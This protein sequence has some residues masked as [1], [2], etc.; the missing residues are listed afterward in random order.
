[1]MLSLMHGGGKKIYV[2]ELD[3]ALIFP[4]GSANPFMS[5]TGQWQYIIRMSI[6]HIN[7]YEFSENQLPTLGKC[8]DTLQPSTCAIRST[9]NNVH[10]CT[11]KHVSKP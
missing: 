1:M 9:N 5:H 10:S 7:K 2:T 4:N 6:K 3:L 11:R 8:R